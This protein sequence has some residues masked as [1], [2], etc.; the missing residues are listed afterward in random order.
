MNDQQLL[1]YSRQILLPEIDHDG[2]EKLLDSSALIIG[3]GGLG[4][5]VALYLAAAGLGKLTIVDHDDVELSNLQRQIVHQMDS[6]GEAKVESARRTLEQLNPECQISMIN[7]VLEEQA[8]SKQV[9]A[10][11][12]VLDCTDNFAS[13]FA[14]NQA[15]VTAKTPL[16]SGAAIRWEGQVAVFDGKQGSP[17]YRCLY[18][19]AEEPEDTCSNTGVLAPVVGIIG[20][21]QATEAIKVLTGAGEPLTGKLL[22]MDAL[23]MQWRSMQLKKDPACP[24]CSN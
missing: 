22:V 17:C 7:H 11:D 12:I 3:M 13:R 18:D 6:I 15:C 2:Q 21:I 20:S 16:V 24:V 19:A 1:H 14:I 10:A 8:L 23:S 9:E 5:P 4:S